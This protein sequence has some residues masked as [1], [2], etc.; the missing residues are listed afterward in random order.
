[1]N[2]HK[3]GVVILA[4]GISERMKTLKAFLP[5]DEHTSFIGKIISTYYDWGCNEIVVVANNDSAGLFKRSVPEIG[6]VTLVRNDHLE[7]ER[8]YSVKL[9]L[10]SIHT[11]DYCFIQNIDNPF[12]NGDILD[13][14]FE[15]RT[16]E[17]FIAPVYDDKGGHPVLLNR[18]SMDHI[19]NYPLNNANLNDVLKEMNCRK[20][21]MKD[22]R[23]LININNKTDYINF[24]KTSETQK[25]VPLS[26]RRGGRGK[27]LKP[28]NE[29]IR[30][31]NYGLY[32]R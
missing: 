20:V 18:R 24:F 28:G 23:I 9:G 12:I 29:L 21:Q 16:P 27:V 10:G 11:S 14:M 31:F 25:I 7:Y 13:M 3:A 19:R 32:F 30:I 1:M 26:F 17:A 4:A 2:P 8:F 5:F 15:Q 22:D 6:N